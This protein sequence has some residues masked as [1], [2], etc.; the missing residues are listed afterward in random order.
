[1]VSHE[2]VARGHL[3]VWGVALGAAVQG[4][5]TVPGITR[6]DTVLIHFL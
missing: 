3:A 5:E 1:M 2:R 6:R 4:S